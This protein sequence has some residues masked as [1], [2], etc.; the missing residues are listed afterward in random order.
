MLIFNYKNIYTNYDRDE[1]LIK[2]LWL[3]LPLVKVL[4]LINKCNCLLIKPEKKIYLFYRIIKVLIKDDS[5][6]KKK[7]AWM[8]YLRYKSDC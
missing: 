2:K 3:R 8:K 4:H 1:K 6:K 7:N 5:K